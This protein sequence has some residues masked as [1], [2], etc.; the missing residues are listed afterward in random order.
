MNPLINP[1]KYSLVVGILIIAF[2]LSSCAPAVTPTPA[3][4]AA[5]T[6]QPTESK[7][8]VGPTPEAT[9]L[10]QYNPPSNGLVAEIKKRGVI[11]NG[12]E[13]QNPP[14]EFYDPT[15]KKC[16]GYSI[17]LA[18]KL[19]DKLGVKLEIIDT[20]WSG[21]IPALYTE[22]FDLIWSSMTITEARKKAVNFSVPYGCDQ[23]TWIVKKGNTSITKPADL[24]GK[25]VATQLN[26]AAEIQANDLQTQS[27]VK[28]KELKSFDHF[29]GA[30]LAVTTG[31]ADIATST[32][33]NN[34]PLFKS[35]PD[36]YD[37]AFTLPIYN[38]VGAA[39]RNQ[40][41]DLAQ[42][43]NDLIKELEA[44]GEMANLQYKYYGYAFECGD[45]GP[46]PPQGWKA[47]Q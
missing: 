19:A 29:D 46:N 16:T 24:N 22:N 1:K 37:V 4:P 7:A 6:A 5:S 15:T 36:A 35:Q 3:A 10:A 33:W 43:V 34:I 21:V 2:V 12:V 26:S 20:A 44:S 39:I 8:S 45:Q 25:V 32:R 23:V 31:Q 42:V 40:D 28:Y 9:G 47:P 38:F 18:Q 13:C 17:D 41:T 11:R 27:G 14:G 30:Y